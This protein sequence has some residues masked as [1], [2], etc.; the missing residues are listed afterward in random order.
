MDR[1]NLEKL[2]PTS[3]GREIRICEILIMRKIRIRNKNEALT[4][5]MYNSILNFLL[6]KQNNQATNFH[7][8]FGSLIC[9]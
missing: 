2:F 9:S 6:L 7:F 5:K 4:W 3:T 1:K 8:Y